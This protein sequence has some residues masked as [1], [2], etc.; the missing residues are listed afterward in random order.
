MD[1]RG[2]EEEETLLGKR[3]S[4]SQGC[5]AGNEEVV[6]KISSRILFIIFA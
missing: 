3:K 4:V 5:G 2:Q 6:R 1:E